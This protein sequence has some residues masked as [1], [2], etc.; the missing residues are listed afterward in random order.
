MN[1]FSAEKRQTVLTLC[2]IDLSKLNLPI[3]GSIFATA[4]T[5][6]KIVLA[7]KMVKID[8]KIIISLI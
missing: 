1:E 4:R 2:F 7:I 8:L 5:V 6:S 3:I